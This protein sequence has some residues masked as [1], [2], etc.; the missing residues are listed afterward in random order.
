M[1]RF[2]YFLT[3]LL[4]TIC[5]KIQDITEL[6]IFIKKKK[7]SLKYLSYGFRGFR[8][9]DSREVEFKEENWESGLNWE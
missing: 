7:Q 2:Q 5:Y 1:L 4:F 6:Y 9:L 8:Y 3:N